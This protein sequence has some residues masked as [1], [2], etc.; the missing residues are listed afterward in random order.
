MNATYKN[1]D[2]DSKAVATALDTYLADLGVLHIKLHNL[3]W[4]VE[5]ES[6]FTLHS[7]MEE[8]YDQISD[9]LDDVAERILALGFRPSASL[10]AYLE[11]SSIKEIGSEGIDGKSLLNTVIADYEHMLNQTK[12]LF[13]ISDAAGDQATADM[14]NEYTARYEKDLWMLKAMNK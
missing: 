14:M 2:A 8:Y 7:K 13:K 11:L 6:F 3:H 5:G 4:N 9:D 10:K 12:E 1:T